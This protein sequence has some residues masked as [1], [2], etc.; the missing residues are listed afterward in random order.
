MAKRKT[1]EARDK[2]VAQGR[3]LVEGRYNYS[4]WEYRIFVSMVQSIKEADREF[5]P[6]RL[7]L[8]D[9][10]EDFGTKSKDDYKKIK[11]AAITLCSKLYHFKYEDK[12]TGELRRFYSSLFRATVPEHLDDRHNKYIELCFNDNEEG[13]LQDMLID[14]RKKGDFLLFDKRNIANLQSRY[15]QRLYPLLKSY[16]NQI[17]VDISVE[18]LREMLLSD[19]YGRPTDQYKKYFLFKKYIILKPQQELK[20]KTDIYFSFKEIKKGRAVHIIRFYVNAN[21]KPKDIK[22]LLR[23]RLTPKKLNL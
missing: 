18:K 16:E 5:K 4:V 7:Y 21:R 12:E 9:L 3:N 10:I 1:Q 20:E 11:N 22:Y 15:S 13:Y 8:N 14:L 2:L 19:I 23:Q 17:F 6:T